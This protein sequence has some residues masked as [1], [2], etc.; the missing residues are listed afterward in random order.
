VAL[1]M[2]I[3]RSMLAGFVAYQS[4]SNKLTV[5]AEII[6]DLKNPRFDQ[7]LSV[8]RALNV[9][10]TRPGRNRITENTEAGS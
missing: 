3:S 4:I 5:T 10:N 8:K 7:R 1:G 6:H 9:D 2:P